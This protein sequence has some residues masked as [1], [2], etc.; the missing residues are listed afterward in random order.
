MGKQSSRPKPVPDQRGAPSGVATSGAPGAALRGAL[1]ALKCVLGSPLCAGGRRGEERTRGGLG[2]ADSSPLSARRG[3]SEEGPERPARPSFS[4]S[5]CIGIRVLQCL[6]AMPETARSPQVLCSLS[7]GSR[8]P[9]GACQVRREHGGRS[10]RRAA[11][12]LPP[13]PLASGRNGDGP[14]ASLMSG[15]SETQTKPQEKHKAVN[16][17][18]SKYWQGGNTAINTAEIHI[19]F[20]HGSDE[21]C[22]LRDSPSGVREPQLQCHLYRPRLSREADQ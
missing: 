10:H 4:L 21:F 13:I 6:R 11:A 12:L 22:A 18:K 19:S 14:H 17:K 7:T 5:F 1:R 9:K 20:C 2:A 15:T 16:I 8:D 3:G